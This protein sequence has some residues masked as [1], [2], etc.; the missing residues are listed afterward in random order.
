M[1]RL[2]PGALAHMPWTILAV[3]PLG[4]L[5]LL[6]GMLCLL[7]ADEFA[8]GPADLSQQ[9]QVRSG[10]AP[11]GSPACCSRLACMARRRAAL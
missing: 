11:L 8:A 10:L 2:A 9:F 5:L 3:M 6:Y 7:F 1:E 4:D